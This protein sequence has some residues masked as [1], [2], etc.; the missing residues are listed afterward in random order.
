M[1]NYSFS[2]NNNIIGN[3]QYDSYFQR[4]LYD[5]IL[6]DFIPAHMMDIYYSKLEKKDIVEQK[7]EIDTVNKT[8]DIYI[9]TKKAKKGYIYINKMLFEYIS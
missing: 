9:K 1:S 4:I 8:R 3:E 5:G 6:V 7:Q 2:Q